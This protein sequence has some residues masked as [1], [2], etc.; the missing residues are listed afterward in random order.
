MKHSHLILAAYLAVSGAVSD[1][2][3]GSDWAQWRGPDGTGYAAN[4]NPP[5][6]WS[7]TNNVRWKA[8][9]PGAGHSS[10]IVVGNRVYLTTAVKTA[11]E[12][13][14]SHDQQATETEPPASQPGRSEPR[15][16]GGRGYMPGP[17][18]TNV[19]KFVVLALDCKDG[20]VAWSAMVH[21]VVPHEGMHR[22]GSFASS[23][24]TTDGEHI[25]AFFGSR[26]LFCLDMDGNVKWEKDL[27]DMRVRNSFGEGASP[28]LYGDTLVVP[29][30]H[31]GESFIV[32]FEKNS[33][34][35][36]WRVNR[37][38]R[39]TWTSPVMVEVN[40]ML[41][42]VVAGNAATISYDL[43]TGEEIW[44][45]SGLTMNVVPTPVVGNGMIYLMSGFR[46]SALLAV[47]LD[48]AEG[49]ISDSDA[50]VWTRDRGTPYVP[51]PLL[52][53][54]KLYLLQSNNG[55]VSCFNAVTGAPYYAS[56]RL[57]DIANVYASLVGA[58][59]RVYVCGREGN[60]VV[61]EDGPDPNV[62]AT[63]SL[64]EGIDATPAIVGDEIYVRGS[65]HLFCIG[66]TEEQGDY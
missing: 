25:Y 64:G 4:C 16:R 8:E 32:A 53:G 5:L 29:W 39:T 44:R 22:T 13:G 26:G 2:A 48:G 24:P 30:D 38:E 55:I 62:L 49:D 34:A 37:D 31:E 18:P 51:S 66:E 12:V 47:K 17:R 63:N 21:E 11:E 23:T 54:E 57:D 27:G 28:V 65:K 40:G 14:P 36:K 46:G 7:Q 3:N 35:Q 15:R 42:V 56:V 1:L 61:L 41:Q 19:Y 43:A 6:E 10:P 45:C 52:S 60:V 20:K 50:I 59:G 9:I 58:A 33:G